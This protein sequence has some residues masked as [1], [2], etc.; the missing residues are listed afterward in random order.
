[1]SY[2][3][4]VGLLISYCGRLGRQYVDNRLRRFDVTPVQSMVLRYL[5][6]APEEQEMTQ[7]DLERKMGLKAPTVNGLVDRMVEKDLVTR[8]TSRSDARCRVVALTEK[9]RTAVEQMQEVIQETEQFYRA[10]LSEGEYREM[11]EMLLRL[12]AEFE[13]EVGKV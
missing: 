5:M 9:G 10:I 2:P 3:E 8:A 6:A 7:R 1:M 11:R 13:K 4:Q 12:I